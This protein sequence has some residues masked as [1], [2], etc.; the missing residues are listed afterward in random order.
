M[1][2]PMHK[3]GTLLLLVCVTIVSGRD[4]PGT[5]QRRATTDPDVYDT[6]FDGVTWD[7]ANWQLTTTTLDQGHYQARMTVANGYHGISVASLGPFF[8]RDVAVDGDVIGGWPLFNR[9]Q[10]FATVG[11][12]WD[13]QPYTNGPFDNGTNFP[14]LVRNHVRNILLRTAD[15]S[16]F[17]ESVWL[18]K[19]H[20]RHP[21]LERYHSRSG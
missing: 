10:T 8:E 1:Q 3:V 13:S 20:Q 14:W 16:R 2:E 17:I 4:S 15:E 18:G 19:H 6:R 11:G 7:N 12:F 9:R 21:A 5:F